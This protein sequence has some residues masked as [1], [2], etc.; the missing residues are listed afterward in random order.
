[1]ARSVLVDRR[2]QAEVAKEIGVTQ[3]RVSLAVASI[4]KVYQQHPAHAEMGWLSLEVDFP[5]ALGVELADVMKQIGDAD[6][7]TQKTVVA[8]I[9]KAIK[10]A[11]LRL[12]K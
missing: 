12:Q 4:A 2:S 11:K 9:I 6:E 10:T 5:A 3:Q 8:T 1:M 7:D